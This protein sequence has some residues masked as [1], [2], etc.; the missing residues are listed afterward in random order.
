MVAVLSMYSSV[1]SIG[2]LSSAGC[3]LIVPVESLGAACGSG[4]VR[5]SSGCRYSAGSV[6]CRIPAY[7]HCPPL[8]SIAPLLPFA[9][10]V[11]LLW[12]H[13]LPSIEEAFL[14]A[15]RSATSRETPGTLSRRTKP[16]SKS[17][18]LVSTRI[19]FLASGM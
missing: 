19:V 3:P 2:Q 8:H 13:G 18:G 10:G 6:G 11:D 14:V 5:S 4:S 17:A 12:Y 16:E 9:D 7:G 15:G 1:D